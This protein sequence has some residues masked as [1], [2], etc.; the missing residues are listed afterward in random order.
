MFQSKTQ[1]IFFKQQPCVLLERKYLLDLII[2]IKSDFI[3]DMIKETK[4]VTKIGTKPEEGQI[5][6]I[7]KDLQKRNSGDIL[8]SL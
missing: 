1:G 8:L 5:V 4:G 3:V 7:K 6:E 2:M